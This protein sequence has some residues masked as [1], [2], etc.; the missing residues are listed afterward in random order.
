MNYVDEYTEMTNATS[1][2]SGIYARLE[3]TEKGEIRI[4]V[5][6]EEQIAKRII[7]MVKTG[8]AQNES[9]EDDLP[10]QDDLFLETIDK[11]T[12]QN[13]P[14]FGGKVYVHRDFK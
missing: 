10:F 6:T 3:N 1:G 8:L 12:I 11:Y 14:A 9:L 2:K 4:L 5:G 13:L 7:F